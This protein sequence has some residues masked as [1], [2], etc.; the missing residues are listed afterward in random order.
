[1]SQS[2][3]LFDALFMLGGGRRREGKKKILP[4]R[5]RVSMDLDPPCCLCHRLQLL[6]AIKG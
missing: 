3:N 4:W 1:M 5:R 6:G 2:L